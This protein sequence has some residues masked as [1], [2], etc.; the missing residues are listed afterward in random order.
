[1]WIEKVAIDPGDRVSCIIQKC[2]N[3][4]GHFWIY[5]SYYV[6]NSASDLSGWYRDGW[7]GREESLFDQLVN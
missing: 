2:P 5:R 3:R 6:E 4:P 7:L 1:M